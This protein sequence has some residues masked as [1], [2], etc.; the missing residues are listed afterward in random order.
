MLDEPDRPQD[1]LLPQSQHR[2]AA[3]GRP[4]KR[5][6]LI[7]DFSV[8]RGGATVLVLL[9]LRLLR[10][11]D[12]A[13]TVIVGDAGAAP[14]LQDLG[15][16]VVA[17]GQQA[18]LAGNPVRTAINGI[19]NQ[20]AA[21]L[22]SGWIAAHDTP[23]TVYHVNIWSQ[24]LSPAIFVPLRRVA[25]RTIIHA[26]D[27]FHACPNGAY[28]D[29]R[30]QEP[31]QRV[32]L[33]VSCLTTHCD[34][35]SYP[36][37]LWR[38]AREARLWAAMG[39][40][41]DWARIV[42]IHEKMAAGLLRAGY[43]P[44]LLT[45]IRNPVLPFSSTR[46]AAEDNDRFIFIGRLE[47]EKGPQDALA[48][49]ERAGLLIDII[50]DG[51]LRAELEARYPQAQFHG[52]RSRDE[53][54]A[55]I[56]KARAIVIPSRLPEPFGLVAAE[57]AASGVPVILTDMAFLADEVVSKGMGLACRTQD[58]DDFAAALR[59]VA[60]LPHPDM[61]VMSE[62]AYARGMSLANTEATWRDAVLALYRE[63][64]NAVSPGRG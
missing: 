50:G 60:A 47:E 16:E 37:K 55:L 7:N 41:P 51:P 25:R 6:V 3:A 44:S 49:A 61:Q 63:V 19:H 1:A 31:C 26:H 13:V 17:L 57:A 32:P 43:E 35:R 33:G 18:L 64:V 4:L 53:I 39:R 36:Q 29:Y 62:N 48:A 30:R 59:H 14:E 54:G 15:V 28:M 42:M 58:P 8:A 21:D 2:P 12:I 24:I 23:E 45:T 9:L 38:V 52:W 5:V 22:L 20:A 34:R 11:Q 10:A 56:Q 40:T 46:I 27:S